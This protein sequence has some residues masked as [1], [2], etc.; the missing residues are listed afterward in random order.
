METMP[1]ARVLHDMV[2]LPDG[3]VLILNGATTGC[4]GFGF[5]SNPVRTAVLYDPGKPKDNRFS[6][7]ASTTIARLYH[8]EAVLALDGRV[9]ISGSTP[10]VDSNTDNSQVIHPTETRIEAYNPP[11]L[12][13]GKQRPEITNIDWYAWTYGAGYIITANIPTGDIANIVVRLI[14][15]SFSNSCLTNSYSRKWNE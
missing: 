10:N 4:G 9:I 8:S 5:A 11:Y 7:L 15:P 12:T 6:I 1:I 3:T 14:A 13:N 2:S